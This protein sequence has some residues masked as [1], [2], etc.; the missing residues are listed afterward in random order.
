MLPNFGDEKGVADTIKLSGLNVPILVQAYP[1]DLDASTSSAAAMPSAARSRSATTCAS[2]ASAFSLTDVHT[3]H[4]HSAELQAGPAEIHRASAGWSTACATRALG[5]IGARPD[6]F[7]TVRYSEKL[8]QAAGI[9]VQHRRPVRDL[10]AAKRLT[11]DDAA[12]AGTSWRR[13]RRYATTD[14]VPSPFPGAHGE[15]RRRHRPT[16]CRANDLDATALQC[17]TSIQK[18][19]GIN[20]CTLMSMMSDQLMPT[21]CEVD[22][23]GVVSMYALQLASGTPSALVDWNNNY[24]DDPDKC[25]LFHCGNWAKTFIPE[26]RDGNTADILGTTLGE[27]N[28]YGAIA[29]RVPAGPMTFARI[30][31]DDP[32]AH[33]RL[34]GRGPASPMIRWTPSA[35]APSWRCRTCRNCSST[36]ASNGFEHHVAMTAAPSAAILAEAFETYLGWEVYRHLGF[37]GESRLSVAPHTPGLSRDLCRGLSC[38]QR[39]KCDFTTPG[40]R[41]AGVTTDEGTACRVCTMMLYR[42]HTVPHDREIAGRD[43]AGEAPRPL[44]RKPTPTTVRRRRVGFA[45]QTAVRTARWDRVSLV[46]PD[47]LCRA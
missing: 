38:L 33:P 3:V 8:L 29:G 11:D 47:K 15:A 32:T 39:G 44:W 43:G 18:N 28:T 27:E 26:H 34:H 37:E 22:I 41:L 12:G 23:T 14:G 2:T 36:S 6:A 19:Y 1:D 24:A 17:W 31:T 20:V 45:V 46:R 42:Q 7:N 35:A 13:S 4:P 5:A 40:M 25:V 9:S 21:A 30:S 16:G 10:G